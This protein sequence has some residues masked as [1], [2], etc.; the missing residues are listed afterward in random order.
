MRRDP[1]EKLPSIA[2]RKEKGK[3]YRMLSFKVCLIMNYRHR[4]RHDLDFFVHPDIPRENVVST[5]PIKSDGFYFCGFR[6]IAYRVKKGD[7]DQCQEGDARLLTREQR[8][9]HGLHLG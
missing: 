5:L 4:P 6:V 2:L 7:Q 1:K 9:L 8:H 3:I